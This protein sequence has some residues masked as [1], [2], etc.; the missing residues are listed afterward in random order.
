MPSCAQHSSRPP[1]PPPPPPAPPSPSI[2]SP[3]F[4]ARLHDRDE[5]P[6]ASEADLAGPWHAEPVPGRP[7]SSAVLRVWESLAAGDLPRAELD[8]EELAQL[9]ALALP[10]LGREPLFHLYTEAGPR[11]YPLVAVDGERGPV[12]C[13]AFALYEPELASALHLLQGLARSP[14]ALAGLIEAAGPG[15]LTQVG[16][17]L[18]G[19]L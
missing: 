5:S 19:R 10:L 17:I 1:V 3:D 4:L 12:E 6:T 8:Q 18:A 16:R 9:C 11:G 13:G 15:A 7:G 2:F 14:A